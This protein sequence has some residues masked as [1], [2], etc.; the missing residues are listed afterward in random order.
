[1][2]EQ[3]GLMFGLIPAV[4]FEGGLL[5]MALEA[6]SLVKT[7]LHIPIESEQLCCLRTSSRCCGASC[8]LWKYKT[9]HLCRGACCQKHDDLPALKPYL[10]YGEHAAQAITLLHVE[11]LRII[12][13]LAW[14]GAHFLDL[15]VAAMSAAECY[16]RRLRHYSAYDAPCRSSYD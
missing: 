5:V 7:A 11:L 12:Q 13:P 15:N 3:C 14:L 1:M 9:R 10:H 16:C 6:L 2:Q 4:L 8:S